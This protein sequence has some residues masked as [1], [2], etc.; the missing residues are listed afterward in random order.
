MSS[1]ATLVRQPIPVP[2]FRPLAWAL[3]WVFPLRTTL[4]QVGIEPYPQEK[5]NVYKEQ[6]QHEVAM[7]L[8]E[9]GKRE[10]RHYG[11]TTEMPH[12]HSHYEKELYEGTVG[13]VGGEVHMFSRW[14]VHTYWRTSP[15]KHLDLLQSAGL[16][17]DTYV[18]ATE[19]QEKLPGTTF[20]VEELKSNKGQYDPLL[21]ACYR[22]ERYCIG[23]WGEA[24]TR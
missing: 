7:H 15:V 22:G 24:L 3:S 19:L 21:F 23:Q 14:Y 16:D 2:S 4:A 1:V 6:M 13:A 20:E 8:V 17:M 11:L 9:E 18:R 10:W 5:V 12:N